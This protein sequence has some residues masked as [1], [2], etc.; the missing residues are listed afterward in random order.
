M[1]AA[2]PPPTPP[3]PPTSKGTGIRILT[4]STECIENILTSRQRKFLYY[5]QDAALLGRAIYMDQVNPFNIVLEECFSAVIRHAEQLKAL[6][7]KEFPAMLGF[8]RQ[9]FT[10]HGM[11]GLDHRKLTPLVTIDKF[12]YFLRLANPE[13]PVEMAS[14]IANY[15]F[16]PAIQ[17]F[18]SALQNIYVS[19]RD[20]FTEYELLQKVLPTLAPNATFEATSETTFHEVVWNSMHPAYGTQIKKMCASLRTAA[21]MADTEEQGTSILE[22]ADHLETGKIC[23]DEY[24]LPWTQRRSMVD[25]NMGFIGFEGDMTK[26]KGLFSA[27]V[28]VI[29]KESVERCR[30]LTDHAHWFES[31]VPYPPNHNIVPRVVMCADLVTASGLAYPFQPRVHFYPTA[32]VKGVTSLPTPKFILF[33]NVL[34][35]IIKDL[36][37]AGLYRS[38]LTEAQ[39]KELMPL[40]VDI[41]CTMFDIHETLAHVS[42]IIHPNAVKLLGKANFMIIDECKAIA[43]TFFM[44]G[45]PRLQELSF[46]PNSTFLKA[47]FELFLNESCVWSVGMFT[48]QSSAQYDD[49]DAMPFT[50]QS[51]QIFAL[52]LLRRGLRSNALKYTEKTSI[53]VL[54]VNILLKDTREFLEKVQSILQHADLADK[55]A[56][57]RLLISV[58]RNYAFTQPANQRELLDKVT[59]G[60]HLLLTLNP[61]L[62]FN[63]QGEVVAQQ[64][65]HGFEGQILDYFDNYRLQV[66]DTVATLH[67]TND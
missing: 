67:E 26:R 24:Y 25:F 36:D 3:A 16:H 6:H 5:L 13:L 29:R 65:K 63:K 59:A 35:A 43:Y 30:I 40:I 2:G 38:F 37:D 22:L 58:F 45:Q 54:D 55:E 42:G 56:D 66:A 62:R 19:T 50:E 32:A 10:F 14:R 34:R 51:S 52:W 4:L 47:A 15:T 57:A 20:T 18:K 41:K 1:S 21:L 33:A 44:M 11:H 39:Y 9:F 8:L 12:V 46:I 64:P 27:L 61:V 31:K 49:P 53:E 7:P 60:T 17:P 23:G 28:W 48:F